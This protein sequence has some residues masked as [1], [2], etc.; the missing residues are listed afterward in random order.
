MLHYY[1]PR[2][3][4]SFLMPLLNSDPL[5][6]PDQGDYYLGIQKDLKVVEPKES[7]QEP[8][9]EIPE[10]CADQII[11]RC[12]DGKEALEILEAWSQLGPPG[13]QWCQLHRQKDFDDGFLL[14]TIYKDCLRIC[15]SVMLVK[16]KAKFNMMEM[17]KMQSKFVRFSILWGIEF[18][19]IFSVI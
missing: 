4:F 2:V 15:K 11:R 7:S 19:G 9:D 18:N 1:D 6:S 14:A 12:V 3:K 5:P 13:G 17:L 8:K 16:D 10:T